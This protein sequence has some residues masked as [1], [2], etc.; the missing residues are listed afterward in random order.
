M[1]PSYE[2]HKVFNDLSAGSSENSPELTPTNI[3]IIDPD[4]EAEYL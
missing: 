4:D 2:L 3:N 1:I